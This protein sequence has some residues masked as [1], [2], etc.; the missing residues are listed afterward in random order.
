MVG[1]TIPRAAWTLAWTLVVAILAGAL[2]LGQASGQEKAQNQSQEKAGVEKP[3][4]P[5]KAVVAVFTLS[6][7]LTETP[8]GEQMALFSAP[9]TSLKEL[10]WRMR[11]AGDDAEVKAVVLLSDGPQLGGGQIEELRQALSYVRSKNKEVLVHSDSM[12]LGEYA[13]YSAASKISVTPTGDLWVMGMQVEQPYIRGLLDKINVL[14]DFLA[15]GEYKS[16]AEIFT[17]TGPSPEADRMTNWLL[18]SMYESMLNQIA[19]GRQTDRA[20]AQ[21]WIDH[22]PYS[23]EK[24]KGLGMI[25]AVEQR[26]SFEAELRTKLGDGVVFEKRYGQKKQPQLDFSSPMAIFRLWG[27]LLG[28]GAG[29]K[30]GSGKPSV[31]IVYVEGPIALGSGDAPPSPFMMGQAMAY[32]GAIRRALDKAAADDSIKAVVLRVN[33]PGGSATASEIILDATRRIKARKPL[34]VSMG[35]VAGSGGYYVA[36]G[37]DTIFADETTLTGSIG[38][39]GGKMVTADMWNSIGIHWKEYTRG[40]NA[41]MMSS[42][43]IFTRDEKARM[44]AWMDEIYATFKRNVTD[45]RGARLKK[46]IDEVAGGRVYTGRQALDLGLVDRIGTLHDAVAYAGEQ[47]KLKD[48]DVRVVPEPKNFIEM[49]MMGAGGMDEDDAKRLDSAPR[50]RLTRDGSILELAL[51]HLRGLDPHKVAPVKQ[52]LLRLEMLRREGVLMMMPEVVM[53]R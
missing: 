13:L 31:A 1:Q 7:P 15:C 37:A 25:D 22:G 36:C 50:L 2:F 47:A 43:H 19:K 39:V 16:A 5:A 17:R 9:G 12:G 41:G 51:P 30:T 27:E 24:A 11:Q 53:P 46:P 20:K 33:S 10:V 4:R 44:Q 48:Y 3:A 8:L 29:K 49:L 21:E 42:N 26:Q 18:D 35:N 40:A 6:G 52:A 38:V 32:S 14:P 34:V 23:A 28:A 45:I